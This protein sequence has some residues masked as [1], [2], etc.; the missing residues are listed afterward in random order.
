ME[1]GH[2]WIRW[3]SVE[4]VPIQNHPQPTQPPDPLSPA[5]TTLEAD[6]RSGVRGREA[7][8]FR[9]TLGGEARCLPTDR[10]LFEEIFP[11]QHP[12]PPLVYRLTTGLELCLCRVVELSIKSS[13]PPPP[14]TPP[15]NKHPH[16][17]QKVLA[18]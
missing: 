13:C 17:F 3:R 6:G 1:T 8:D 18:V 12:P 14:Y 5:T 15:P 10:G 9:Y 16:L 2:I 7:V 4:C 11:Q